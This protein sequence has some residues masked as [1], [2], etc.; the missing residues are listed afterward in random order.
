M[1]TLAIDTSNQPMS[2]AIANDM[3]LLGEYT[4]NIKRNHSVQLMPAIDDLLKKVNLKPTDLQ[5][6]VV[7]EGPGSYTGL[8]IGMTVAKTLAWTLNI[9]IIP[10]SSLKV[11]A[12]NFIYS[13]GLICPFFDARRGNVF[14]G[15]Y[16]ANNGILANIKED[17]NVAMIDWLIELK[18]FN[19]PII[20][21]SPNQHNFGELIHEHLS[22]FAIISNQINNIPRASQL[23]YLSQ[24]EE[25][26]DAHLVKPQ[27]HRITEAEA[28]LKKTNEKG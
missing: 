28:N 23:I 9:P 7:A 2:I 12:A 1:I 16:E 21:A 15:L 22:D 24:N 8:R 3:D 20:F 10:V 26:V 17:C 11:L 27:Y 19:R 25:K 6:I 5:Q 13:E 18:Q 4:I 14:T